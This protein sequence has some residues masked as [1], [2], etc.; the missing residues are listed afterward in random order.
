MAFEVPDSS[1]VWRQIPPE[2]KLQLMNKSHAAGV[3][4]TVIS[5]IVLSTIAVGLHLNWLVWGSLLC[6]PFVFQFASG[7]RWRTLRPKIMLEYLAARSAA[8]RFAYSAGSKDMRVALMLKGSLE[9]IFDEEHRTE[10]LEAEISDHKET[11]V[12]VAL[13]PDTVI[14]MSERYGGA[15][16]EFGYILNDKVK[17]EGKS[18]VGE[19][20]YSNQRELYFY[21]QDK[22]KENHI[23][24]LTSPFPAALIVFEKKALQ[25]QKEFMESNRL[26]IEPEGVNSFFGEDDS[27][28]AALFD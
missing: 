18:P 12:W 24:R 25:F 19:G 4:A 27:S 10:E 22:L 7:K 8:R 28:R 20:D 3:L 17:I 16:L 26:A 6:S 1:E 13:F 15:E 2:E 11:P 14:M 23:Y 9:E 21:C 5:I